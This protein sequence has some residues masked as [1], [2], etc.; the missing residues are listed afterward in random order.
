MI[1]EKMFDK[2]KSGRLGGDTVTDIKPLRRKIRMF[3][4]LKIVDIS[5]IFMR[6]KLEMKFLHVTVMT[7]KA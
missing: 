1:M 2:I 6:Q 5:S 3:I 7:Y 4:N